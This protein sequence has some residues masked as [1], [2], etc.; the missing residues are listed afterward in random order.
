MGAYL[1]CANP[2][3]GN[4]A[5]MLAAAGVRRINVSLDTLDEATFQRIARRPGLDSVLTGISAAQRAGFRQ[6]RLNAVAIR[7]ITDSE[8]VPLARFA[9]EHDCELRFIEFMPLD[10]DRNWDSSQV[11]T[12]A[13]LRGLI[14]ANHPLEELEREPSATARVFRFADGQGEIG[15]ISPVSEPFCSDCNRLRLTADGNLRTCLFSLNE[16]A[17]RE[18][19]RNGA[20]DTD[21]EDLIRMAVRGK[22]LRH[23]INEIGFRQPGRTMS[24]IGG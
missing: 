7:G 23:R 10:G 2:V 1:I 4:V 6:I 9:R 24:S 8:I 5:P 13:D 11:L 14:E 3:Q 15:F 17:L 21:L 12:G 19:M 16:T 18:P 22:E 20:S